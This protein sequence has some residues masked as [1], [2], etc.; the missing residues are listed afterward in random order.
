MPPSLALVLTLGFIA[1]LVVRDAVRREPVDG[2][3]WIPVFW[4]VV[5]GSRFVS[6]WINLG[7]K[8]FSASVSEGS[9]LDAMY[10]LVLI[11][12]GLIVL[13][14]RRV[15][16]AEVLRKNAWL[17]AFAV[18]AFVSILWSDFPFIALKRWIK[19]LGHPVM[20]LLVLTDPDPSRALRTVL[21]RCGYFFLPMSVLFIRYF[22]E[23][24]RGFD[25][26]D[27]AAYNRGIGLTKND[28]GYVCMIMGLFFSWNLLS[29]STIPDK[30]SR[31]W[32]M[33]L[34]AG[35]LAMVAWLLKSA[36]SATSLV[37]LVLGL[38]MLIVL[39]SG[40]VNYR[41]LGTYFIVGVVLITILEVGFDIYA[42]T[43]ELLGRDPNLTDRTAVWTDVIA[44][45]PNVAIGA[46]FESFWLGARL[47]HMWAKWWWHPSQ[48]HN[49]YIEIYLNLGVIGLVLLVG[50][51]VSAFR[52]IKQQLSSD[53]QRDFA[54]LRLAFLVAILAYN[55][56]EAAFKGVH[57]VWTIFHLVAMD[58]SPD[59]SASTVTPE[60]PHRP[61]QASVRRHRAIARPGITVRLP[62]PHGRSKRAVHRRRPDVGSN[63]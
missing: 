5:T 6:Q 45:Q 56:T 17:V 26:W 13:V 44:L 46:G 22:P 48:A 12:V 11:M 62:P 23:Y 2:A 43:I 29:A 15:R 49:G 20:A 53:S 59:Y 58:Y 61:R 3:L 51:L 54:Q 33:A 37:T 60:R 55:Y 10:F 40:L 39:R 50:V 28:L 19:T 14:R 30:G 52:K 38:A 21:R 7:N 27:G 57:L 16:V 9:P 31:N 32:E 25:A 1:A 35:F 34:S 8:G 42:G 4:M 36:N 18:Y 47:E 63:R 41:R 24:G